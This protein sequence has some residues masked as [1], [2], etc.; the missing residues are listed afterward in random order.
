MAIRVNKIPDHIYM[1]GEIFGPNIGFAENFLGF[2]LVVFK[3]NS[4]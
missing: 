2:S 3:R 1:V 4:T